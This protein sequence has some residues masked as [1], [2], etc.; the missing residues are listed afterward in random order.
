[1][2]LAGKLPQYPHI[3]TG[4]C[5][6]LAP[7]CPYLTYSLANL[8]GTLKHSLLHCWGNQE[9]ITTVGDR[10][11]GPREKTMKE[12]QKSKPRETSV[13]PWDTDIDSTRK[14]MNNSRK[15][16]QQGLDKDAKTLPASFK[17][18]GGRH[19]CKNLSNN[20]KSNMVTPEL[21]GHTTA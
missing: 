14:T 1:M 7:F 20:L 5:K 19:Q 3:S 9:L 12:D 4:P 17:G 10:K 6:L 18:R 16:R 11:R 8:I 2:F 15:L 13:A 21:H